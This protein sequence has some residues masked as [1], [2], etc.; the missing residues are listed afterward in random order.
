M[1]KKVNNSKAKVNNEKNKIEN[2]GSFDTDIFKII[3]VV[4]GVI[5]VFCIFY[6]VTI[7]VLNKDTE[8]PNED[9]EVIISLDETIVGRSLN[10]PEEKYYVLYYDNSNEEVNE[11]Y[12][13]KITNYIYST[14]ESKVKLYT[15]DMSNALN[16]TYVAEESN[17]KPEKAS[18]IAIKGTTLMIVEKGKVIDYIEDESRIEDLLQ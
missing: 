1:K 8:K 5:C 2:V 17:T 4:L 7:L 3:Y 18:D 16:K 13:S 11:K 9:K 12:S 15:V 14:D 6:L 10:M